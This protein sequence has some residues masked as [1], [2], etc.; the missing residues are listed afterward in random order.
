VQAVFRQH[1]SD[2][3]WTLSIEELLPPSLRHRAS[4]LRKGEDT[5]DVWFDSGVSWDSVLRE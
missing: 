4:S 1:G 5:M 2:A 3:W